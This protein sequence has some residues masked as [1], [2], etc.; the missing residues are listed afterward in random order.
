M[1][2]RE[3]IPW[4]HL[5]EEYHNTLAKYSNHFEA[6]RHNG[7]WMYPVKGYE[8]DAIAILRKHSTVFIE[9]MQRFKKMMDEGIIIAIFP[10]GFSCIDI[11]FYDKNKRYAKQK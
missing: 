5:P 6:L 8:P 2:V 4:Y 10:R 1:R 11:V 9:E 7:K 3:C